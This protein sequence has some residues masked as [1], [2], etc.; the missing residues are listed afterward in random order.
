MNSLAKELAKHCNYAYEGI[1]GIED[2]TKKNALII[3][4]ELKKG[5]APIVLLDLIDGLTEE[6]N[7]TL[8]SMEDGALRDLFLARGIDVVI[9][10]L[11]TFS[12]CDK[13]IWTKFD[14]VLA[15]TILSY[16]F[17]ACFQNTSVSVLW[18]LHEPELLFRSTYGRCI[19]FGILSDNIR[20]LPVTIETQ[21][22]IKKYY[23]IE[24][25]ILHMGIEDKYA[26]ESER[27]DDKVRFFQPAKFQRIKG[28]DILAQ[29]IMSLPREYMERSEFYFAGM[30]DDGQPE[31]Y[32]LISKLSVAFPNVYML[33]EQ[34]REEIYDYYQQ[35]DCVVAPSRA[36]ATPTTIVE[37]MMFRKVALC[38][39]ATGI[40][41]YLEDGVNGYVFPSEDVEAL[42]NKIMYIIDNRNDLDSLRD[43]G[44]D[45]YLQDFEISVARLHLKQMV[46]ELECLT[47]G[48]GYEA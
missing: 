15:N 20:V 28:Q 44:R 46:S 27:I 7:I 25:K 16:S 48:D 1:T 35:I 37:G 17:M 29:A 10:N 6:Y 8:I 42:K 14:F 3:S 19:P 22:C 30:R 40:S 33:G 43:K 47:K 34:S 13:R 39:D 24:S 12:L 18:W 32:E 4:H 11:L 36:D 41:N 38:S 21:K 5:G 31:Y 9:G 23:G 45:I 2:S 26:G